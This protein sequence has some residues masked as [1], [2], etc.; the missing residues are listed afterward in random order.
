VPSAFFLEYHYHK[1]G[2]GDGTRTDNTF[3]KKLLNNF[4]NFILLDKGMTIRENIGRK[5][6]R[7]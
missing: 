4:L 6:A 3:F 1:R 2:I 5:D 7:Y